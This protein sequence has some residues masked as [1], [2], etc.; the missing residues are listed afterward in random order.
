MPAGKLYYLSLSIAKSSLPAATKGSCALSLISTLLDSKDLMYESRVR[1]ELTA[2]EVQLLFAS[3]CTQIELL[4][5]NVQF[6]RQGLE[7]PFFI[8][9]S[10]CSFPALTPSPH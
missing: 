3:V 5:L 10:H 9:L 6:G 1:G 4:G 2:N 7:S 8:P